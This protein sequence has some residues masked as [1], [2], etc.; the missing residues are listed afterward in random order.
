MRKRSLLTT[1]ALGAVAAV[2]ASG[3][4]KVAFD[5]VDNPTGDL[6]NPFPLYIAYGQELWG[7]YNNDGKL[8]RF[9][10]GGNGGQ[11]FYLYRNEG[12][13]F[14]KVET[15]ITP[16]GNATAVLFDYD[17]DGNLDILTMGK[18]PN[19]G[20]I[21]E[22]W[23]NT[24]EAGSYAFEKDETFVGLGLCDHEGQSRCNF[25]STIDYNNDGWID[26]VGMGYTDGDWYCKLYE[27][28]QGYFEEVEHPVND[29]NGR[30]PLRRIVKGSVQVADLNNDGY[31]DLIV[32]GED[33]G[34]EYKT[35]TTIYFN[36][37]DGTF[38]QIENPAIF[39][40]QNRG[41]TFAVDINNDG[42]LDIVEMG[43]NSNSGRDLGDGRKRVANIYFNNGN[44]TFAEAIV[45]EQSGI[46]EMRAMPAVGDV[47]NDGWIDILTTGGWEDDYMHLAY[48]NGDNT[49]TD[50]SFDPENSGRD[51]VASLVD[52]DGDGALDISVEGWCGDWRNVIMLNNWAEGLAAPQA[53]N[54]PTGLAVEQAGEDV[55]L[56]WNAATDD[57]TP[58]EAI[59]YN[60]YIQAKE[61]DNDGYRYTYTYAPADVA[62]GFLTHTGK[63]HFIGGTTVT[64]KGFNAADY[65]FGVQA[66][67]NGWLASE[68][69]TVSGGVSVGANQYE[70]VKVYVQDGKVVVENATEYTIYTLNGQ[71]VVAEADL[72]TGAY[73]VKVTTANETVAKKVVVM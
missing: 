56:T 5:P 39:A 58:T 45:A 35:C 19:N 73:V 24:G 9:M 70:D 33:A 36:N 66:I 63:P 16:L 68:F 2:F 34:D 37:G 55:V 41:T 47:N 69:F 22:L 1:F 44:E 21:N 40:G 29:G 49:F 59:R 18:D 4:V 8:D 30:G 72:T 12:S 32:S 42:Y 50:T 51:G 14:T 6:E 67:D 46:L 53:P 7:D 31:A 38:K 71:A 48:N 52:F 10:I 20:T 43:D 64:M 17:N 13:F 28:K 61:A 3:P 15:A 65:N 60:I 62:T 26:I 27:N 25:L 23:R 54:A 57:T 11:N